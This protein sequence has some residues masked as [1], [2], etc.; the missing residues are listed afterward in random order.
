MKELL[1]FPRECRKKLEK[2][3]I[4]EGENNNNL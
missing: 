4:S 3:L 1:D 2:E